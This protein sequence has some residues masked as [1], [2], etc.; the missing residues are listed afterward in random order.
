MAA[1]R[2]FSVCVE[3]MTDGR[4]EFLAPRWTCGC[5]LSD[6]G[7]W[8]MP[9]NYQ[10]GAAICEDAA[11]VA[12]APS[13]L[14]IS[15][16]R[17]RSSKRKSFVQSEKAA[18]EVREALLE[19][20]RREMV[21]EMTPALRSRAVGLAYSILHNQEDAEDAVQSAMLS[22]YVHLRNF[23]GRSAFTTWFNRIVMN[24]ALMLRRKRKFSRIEAF[25]EHGSVDETP[26][27]ERVP[28][29]QADPEMASATAEAF[30]S[31][32][33]FLTKMNPL[34]RQAFTMAYYHEFSV[35]EACAALG[36]PST[37]FKA[38]VFRAKQLLIRDIRRS[39]R[40]CSRSGIRTR[41][42]ACG[43]PIAAAVAS[44]RSSEMSSR[45]EV[46]FG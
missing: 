45:R 2:R 3:N 23:E 4:F 38:R 13:V 40:G 15:T 16:E 35:K 21:Q 14:R 31:I 36:V 20:R 25:P 34:L 9:V 7:E 32:E 28:A 33:E 24:S 22:A 26:W 12:P 44:A 18:A 19:D 30:R 11:Y 1:L 46:A 27:I 41:F 43:K 5:S 42:S 37:T 10:F 17:H 39:Q 6:G 8:E 29:R